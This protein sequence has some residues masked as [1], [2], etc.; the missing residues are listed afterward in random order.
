VFYVTDL[1]GGKVEGTV[2]LKS[3]EKRLLEAATGVVPV[4]DK[5]AA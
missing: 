2:R 1:I 3:L 5:A 4:S